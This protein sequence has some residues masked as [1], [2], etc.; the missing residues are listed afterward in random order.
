M[1]SCGAKPPNEMK[2]G[3]VKYPKDIRKQNY[4]CHTAKLFHE[5]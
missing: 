3:A 5:I 1:K 4:I 2:S